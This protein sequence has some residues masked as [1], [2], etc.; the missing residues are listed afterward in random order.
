MQH[1]SIN[2]EVKTDPL[3]EGGVYEYTHP[4]GQKETG[5]I[6]GTMYDPIKEV[7]K[8]NLYCYSRANI[9]FLVQE[10]T[11]TMSG[12]RLIARPALTTV[13]VSEPTQPAETP[14]AKRKRRTKA[15]MEAARAAAK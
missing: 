2:R 1:G 12:W 4:G 9:P 3:V 8:G 7:T 5:T 6:M 13:A 10:G 14:K 11:E 15:Q